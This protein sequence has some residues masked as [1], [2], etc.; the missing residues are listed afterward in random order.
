MVEHTPTPWEVHEHE[1]A[2][3][4]YWASIGYQGRGPIVDI[5]GEQGSPP[6]DTDFQEVGRIQHL[7]TPVEQQKANAALIV[8]AVNN[9]DR[10]EATLEVL[11][12]LAEQNLGPSDDILTLIAETARQALATLNDGGGDG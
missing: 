5:V 6:L 11:A 2:D 3:G 9:V 1:H 12:N 4:E 7:I 8:R 10:L